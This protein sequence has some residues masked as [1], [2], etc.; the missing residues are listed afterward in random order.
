MTQF[1]DHPLWDFAIATYTQD[2]VAEICLGLQE[3]HGTDV[4]ILLACAWSGLRGQ[5]LEQDGVEAL[6]DAVREWHVE[7]VIALRQVRKRMKQGLDGVDADGLQMSLRAQLQ[8]LEI[9]MEHAEQLR[10]GA[11]LDTLKTN[12]EAGGT[13]QAI[14]NMADYLGALGAP[15]SPET[16]AALQQIAD[17][18]AAVESR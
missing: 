15:Q 17:A 7:V 18:G 2:G 8:K 4:N 6:Q 5:T 13:E 12:N 1:P 16:T 3:A 11:V 14:A 10:L 9:D